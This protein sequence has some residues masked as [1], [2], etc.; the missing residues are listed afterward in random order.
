[1]FVCVGRVHS[2]M[3]IWLP[4]YCKSLQ[5]DVPIYASLHRESQLSSFWDPIVQLF[6]IPISR[7]VQLASIPF[8]LK[9]SCGGWVGSGVRDA[10]KNKK[11]KKPNR[12]KII[13]IIKPNNNDLMSNP[14]EQN[15]NSANNNDPSPPSRIP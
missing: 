11:Q 5:K 1:M 9:G 12:S 10:S 2:D 13:E 6:S 15:N 8:E 3:R 14:T 4:L 7:T